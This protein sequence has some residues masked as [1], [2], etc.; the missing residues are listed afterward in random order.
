MSDGE[1]SLYDKGSDEE[2]PAKKKKTQGEAFTNCEEGST[3]NLGHGAT[4]C[5]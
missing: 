3:V 5:G 2:E 1:G 4:C